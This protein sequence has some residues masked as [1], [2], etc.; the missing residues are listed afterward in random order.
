MSTC[1]RK[2]STSLAVGQLARREPALRRADFGERRFDHA[3][4]L[5]EFENRCLLDLHL[6]EIGEL[7]EPLFRDAGRFGAERERLRRPPLARGDKRIAGGEHGT[8]DGRNRPPRQV[9]CGASRTSSAGFRWNSSLRGMDVLVG[10]R[11]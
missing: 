2:S 8:N 7:A 10:G 6:R 9:A 11:R 5:G 3:L 1:L 4:A